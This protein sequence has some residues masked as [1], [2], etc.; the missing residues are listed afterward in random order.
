MKWSSNFDKIRR[1][2]AIRERQLAYVDVMAERRAARRARRASRP[3]AL[4]VVI[5]D[6]LLLADRAAVRGF[7]FSPA[8]VLDG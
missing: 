6:V 3:R 7:A 5:A 4:Q 2:S 8:S 1:K